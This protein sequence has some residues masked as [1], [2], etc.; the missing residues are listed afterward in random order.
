MALTGDAP[1]QQRVRGAA[2]SRR[3]HFSASP[4]LLLSLVLLSISASF[5][6]LAPSAASAAPLPISLAATCAS[7]PD[8]G[9]CRAAFSRHYYN[10]TAGS[11]AEFVWGGCGGNANNYVSRSACEA[12]CGEAAQTAARN[13]P[14]A[15]VPVSVLATAPVGGQPATSSSS[16]VV[17][18]ASPPLACAV[19][20]AALGFALALLAP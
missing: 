3:A 12:A 13:A 4:L 5:V 7:P 11:C 16:S 17:G 1:Q 20:L 10:S 18:P 2:T 8:A 9:P 14:P 19:V 15:G 6:V